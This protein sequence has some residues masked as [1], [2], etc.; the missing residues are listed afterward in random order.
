MVV[1]LGFQI[2]WR[3]S[4]HPTSAQGMAHVALVIGNRVHNGCDFEFAANPMR[5]AGAVRQRLSDLGFDV[6]LVQ[7]ARQ[8][9]MQ[10]AFVSF[11]AALSPGCS[12]VVYYCGCGWQ[13]DAGGDCLLV[14]VDFP[15]GDPSGV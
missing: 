7:S 9:R 2:P 8:D 15:G 3:V 4:F 6:T 10:A 1:E 12:A 13:A 14:P 11:L 5:S